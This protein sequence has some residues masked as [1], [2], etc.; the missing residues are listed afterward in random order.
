M[1][2][3]P[4]LLA[5]GARCNRH[6]YMGTAPPAFHVL[7]RTTALAAVGKLELPPRHKSPQ[8]RKQPTTSLLRFAGAARGCQPDLRAD[9][10]L[11]K[12]AVGSACHAERLCARRPRPPALCL[13]LPPLPTGA[14]ETPHPAAP[15]G[16]HSSFSRTRRGP[17]CR[18]IASGSCPPAAPQPTPTLD[19][20]IVGERA[21]VF[22]PQQRASAFTTSKPPH[23]GSSAMPGD[24]AL[25]VGHRLFLQG[26]MASGWLE[27]A[28]AEALVT[29]IAA[30][31]GQCWV[32]ARCCLLLAAHAGSSA[33]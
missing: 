11:R 23:C 30:E 17:F 3:P 15:S 22:W 6:I 28:K 1:Y 12:A 27:S 5:A 9:G 32:G 7:T 33:S 18:T 16:T 26:L 13:R 25:S 4:G 8:Q 24:G 2:G 31:T 19:V 14:S 29:K 21:R 10:G 20:A